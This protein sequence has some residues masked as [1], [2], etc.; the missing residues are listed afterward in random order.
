MNSD[1]DGKANFRGFYG[2]YDV[3]LNVDGKIITKEIRLTK[4]AKRKFEFEI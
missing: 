1:E 2:K 3:E 4:K